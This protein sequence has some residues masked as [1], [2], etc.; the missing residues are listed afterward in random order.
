MSWRRRHRVQQCNQGQERRPPPPAVYPSSHPS[1]RDKCHTTHV[2]HDTRTTTTGGPR[3]ER[4][5]EATA[6]VYTSKVYTVSVITSGPP[7]SRAM[8]DLG[9]VP[10]HVVVKL[11]AW[12]EA[13]EAEGLELVRRVPGFHDEAL[14]GAR[15]GQRSIRLSR[16]YRAIYVIRQ[17]GQVEF[18]SVEEV[19][20]HDY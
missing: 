2:R 20:K 18:V 9:K 16:A 13:V 14:K 1:S 15:L 4:C 11:M 3:T 17:G 7:H 19:N 12:V 5:P 10:H 6:C 8:K